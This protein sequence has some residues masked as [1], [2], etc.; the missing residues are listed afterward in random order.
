MMGIKNYKVDV[1]DV[2]D[3]TAKPMSEDA[4]KE[5]EEVELFRKLSGAK[6]ASVLKYMKE[7][8]PEE[9]I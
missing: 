4:K 6:R 2:F 7:N 9:C 3:N 8:F 1:F 5:F